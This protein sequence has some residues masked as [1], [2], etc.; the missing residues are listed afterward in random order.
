MHILI[1]AHALSTVTC[2]EKTTILSLSIKNVLYYNSMVSEYYN[3][4]Y[5]WESA[6]GL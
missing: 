3:I 2:R 6:G 5:Q 1:I 4:T